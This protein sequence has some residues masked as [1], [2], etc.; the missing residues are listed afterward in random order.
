MSKKFNRM[1]SLFT[2]S[3]LTASLVNIPTTHAMENNNIEFSYDYSAYEAAETEI[4]SLM[5]NL[6][7]R[8]EE[9]DY[10]EIVDGYGTG[11]A[12]PR[13]EEYELLKNIPFVESVPTMTYEQLPSSINLTTSKYFPPVGNQGS[14]GS[15]A[16]WSAGYYCHTFEQAKAHDLDASSGSSDAIM[17]VA[18]LYNKVNYG[19]DKGSWMATNMDVATKIGNA[20][21][22]TM[23]YNPYDYSSWGE[24][25]AWREAPKYKATGYEQTSVK[26]IEVIKSWL[27]EGSLVSIA[28]DAN[29]Y[30]RAFYDNNVMSNYEYYAGRPNHANTIVGYD[31]SITDDGEQGAFL[32]VNSW[33]DTWGPNNDGTFYMTYDCLKTLAHNVGIRYTG[34]KYDE[35]TSPELIATWEFSRK[36]SRDS[37]I[38]V[39]LGSS[40]Q[41]ATITT[42]GTYL[43]PSFMALDIT[44]MKEDFELGESRFELNTGYNAGTVS[45]FNIELYDDFNS[46]VPTRVSDDAQNVPANSPA[47]VIVDFSY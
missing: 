37:D 18:W 19:Q 16:A 47:T 12:P 26:N 7:I 23:P 39:S 10:N 11:F 33:G 5:D 14:Q 38:N 6:G 4:N 36:G 41:D 25:V 35:Y 3:V 13:E 40:N 46:G 29:Q 45:A 1:C 43:F 34:A 44:D 15:C 27:A 8:D 17:S 24:E 31:D 32:I 30:N 9:V 28:L 2:M 21:E 22:T 20:S 42:G